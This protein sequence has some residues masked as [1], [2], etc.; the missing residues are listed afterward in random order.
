MAMVDLAPAPYDLAD[1]AGAVAPGERLDVAAGH[2]LAASADLVALGTMATAAARRQHGDRVRCVRVRHALAGEHDAGRA[3]YLGL[4]SDEGEDLRYLPAIAELLQHPDA[5]ADEM[6][7]ILPAT[8][9]RSFAA[10]LDLVRAVKRAMPDARLH[11]FSAHDVWQ[12]CLA[13]HRPVDAILR[14]LRAAGLDALTGGGALV[15]PARSRPADLVP[16]AEWLAIHRAAHRLGIPSSATL[17]FGR[18]ESPAERVTHL[19]WL[20]ELQDETGGFI[21]CVPFAVPPPAGLPGAAVAEL[22][23][24]AI[25][26]L[27]LD[28]IPTIRHTWDRAGL[29]V[30]QMALGFGAGALGGAQAPD[31]RHSPTYDAAVAAIRGMGRL[32]DASWSQ[33]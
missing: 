10:Y 1:I 32:V 2:R 6:H 15:L 17:G 25:A 9:D 5:H 4:P 29:V 7:L 23:W 8:L 30:A 24:L 11:A 20:R 19:L 3:A 31:G 27:M 18:G 33:R 13:E 28:N 26:R 22:Q 16:A 14:E 12:L 21:D